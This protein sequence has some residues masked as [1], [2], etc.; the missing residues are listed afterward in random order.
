MCAGTVRFPPS[1]PLLHS[2]LRILSQPFVPPVAFGF[3]EFLALP[4]TAASPQ[5]SPSAITRSLCLHRAHTH[6]TRTQHTHSAHPV[7]LPHFGQRGVMSGRAATP[8]PA[9]RFHFLCTVRAVEIVLQL[10]EDEVAEQQGEG[11]RGAWR[12]PRPP[13]LEVVRAMC[14]ERESQRGRRQGSRTG[15]TAR[16]GLLLTHELPPSLALPIALS[17]VDVPPPLFQLTTSC[18]HAQRHL[19]LSRWRYCHVHPHPAAF[20][21]STRH[22]APACLLP[23]AARALCSFPLSPCR[24]ASSGVRACC[25]RKVPFSATT[26]TLA[27]CSTLRLACHEVTRGRKRNVSVLRR[28]GRRC[29][30]AACRQFTNTRRRSRQCPGNLPRPDFPMSLFLTT[31]VRSPEAG[32]RNGRRWRGERGGSGVGGWDAGQTRVVDMSGG[33]MLPNLKGKR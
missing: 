29:P 25:G 15:H 4:A 33:A 19:R 2:L 10:F 20:H 16:F 26:R 9:E 1:P 5:T 28:N 12:G 31:I 13:P 6:P 17:D 3:T 7:V 22:P 14:G 11:I 18:R 21:H 23:D 8:D 24:G 30:R 27:V 32:M